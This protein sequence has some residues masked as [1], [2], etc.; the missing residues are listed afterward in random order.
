M[1]LRIPSPAALFILVG[2]AAAM[3]APAGGDAQVVTPKTLPVHQADQFFIFPSSRAGMANVGIAVDDSLLDPFAN[4]ARATQVG[5]SLVFGAPFR[6]SISG[7]RGGGRTLPFG[8]IWSG[9]DWAG[10]GLVAL[11]QLDR[12]G[13]A[14]WGPNSQRTATNQYAAASL[15]RRVRDGMSI[16]A[17]VYWADL[18]AIDGVD[19][20]YAGSDTIRQEGSVSDF[21]LGLTKEWADGRALDVVATHSRTD[22]THDVHFTT[23]S[24][25]PAIS[26]PTI[27]TR[28]EHN[29]DRTHIW[30]GHARFQRPLGTQ[31]WRMGWIA[32]ATRLSHP[33]IPNYE[34][35][36]VP[37]DPGTTWGYNA[38]IG[39]SHTEGNTTFGFDAVLEPMFSETWADAE[40]DTAT[41]S[42]G[43]IPKGGRT[44]ENEFRFNNAILRFGFGNDPPRPDAGVALGYQLGVGVHSIRYR[45]YQQNHVLENDRRQTEQWM[46]WAPTFALRFRSRAYDLEYAFRMTCGTGSCGSG[47][48][49][50][51]VPDSFLRSGGGGGVIIAAPS[52][53]IDF[54]S[55]TAYSHRV[56]IAVPI[57]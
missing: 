41:V 54:E 39:V 4:P 50:F 2:A 35:M 18:G 32:T 5:N 46:E 15:A 20:L 26:S 13:A 57:R 9:G 23:W 45:L 11:Q 30:S 43:T 51:N 34:I 56:S 12:A 49:N 48:R 36:N 16:G 24:W 31:G 28:E 22:M 53:P 55:G 14:R 17:S 25:D 42:G 6:H 40:R 7:S 38:G 21:R 52:R 27:A 44:V 29:V 8:A 37:R 1:R 10:S 3:L 19:L 33:K 47:D